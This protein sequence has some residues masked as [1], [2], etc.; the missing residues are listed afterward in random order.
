[1]AHNLSCE[2]NARSRL[3]H[4]ILNADGDKVLR[5]LTACAD[6]THELDQRSQI[7]RMVA[8][9]R[10]QP[11]EVPKDELLAHTSPRKQPRLQAQSQSDT[12]DYVLRSATRRYLPEKIECRSIQRSHRRIDVTT[13]RS[14]LTSARNMR[15]PTESREPAAR[16]TVETSSAA[17]RL[18]HLGHKNY[19]HAQSASGRSDLG[20]LHQSQHYKDSESKRPL[21]TS[22]TWIDP[23]P[24]SKEGGPDIVIGQS[25]VATAVTMLNFD[26]GDGMLDFEVPENVTPDKRT[27]ALEALPS[28]GTARKRSHPGVLTSA[29]ASR[30]WSNRSIGNAE[31]EHIKFVHSFDWAHTPLGPMAEWDP[32]LRQMCD[33]VMSSP[34]PAALYWGEDLTTVYNEAYIVLAGHKHPALMGQSYRIAWAEIWDDVS[35]I[36]ARAMSTG[37]ATMKEDDRLFVRRGTQLEETFF[38][39]SIVPV[40]GKDGSVAGLYNPAFEKTR[41]KIAERR[42]LTLR[43]IGEQTAT[44]KEVRH[45][46]AQV[47]NTFDCNQFDSP[48]A[49][50]YSVSKRDLCETGVIHPSS[51]R[52]VHLC[53]LEGSI[54]VPRGHDCA[55]EYIP[56]G[57]ETNDFGSLFCKAMDTGKPVLLEI[58]THGLPGEKFRDLDW[59]GFG[60]PCKSA[61][62]CPLH[63]TTGGAILGFLVIGI[64]PRRPYDDDYGLFVELLSRQLGTALASVVLF[65]DEIRR[66]QEAAKLA[67]LDRVKLTTQLAVRTKEAEDIQ[68]KF[69]RMAELSPVGMFIASSGGSTTFAN[70]SWYRISRMPRDQGS[71]DRWMNAVKE[72]DQPLAERMWKTLVVDTKPVSF[73]LRFEAVWTDSRGDKGDMWVL[74]SG[75]PELDDEG[76]L[77]C[78]FGSITDISEQKWAES[79]QIKKMEE[80]MELKRQQ[81]NFID[82]TSHEMRNPLSA[83]LQCSDEITG[84][85]TDLKQADRSVALG[86][87]ITRCLEAALTISLCGQ[88]QKRIVDDILTLSRLDSRLL[89]VTP[90]DAQ[91]LA[92]VQRLLKLHESEL[93]AADVE[94]ESVVDRSFHDMKL[95]WLKFDPSRVLQVLINLTTNA[96]KFTIGEKKR[97]ITITVRATRQRPSETGPPLV[98]YVPRRSN[99]CPTESSEWGPG[100]KVFILFSVRDTG[101]GLSSEEKRLLFM[102]FSQASP[103]THVQYGGSGLGLFISRE[104]TELQGG[105][106]GVES[107]AGRG[108]IFAFYVAARRSSRSIDD[109]TSNTVDCD[110]RDKAELINVAADK[111]RVAEAT[112]PEA[113]LM[114]IHKRVLIVEDNLVNQKVLQRQLESLGIEVHLANHGREA[115]DK[116]SRS[117]FCTE[118]EDLQLDVVLMDQEMPVMDGMTCTR[119]IRELTNEGTIRGH[120][121]I[122]GITANARPEQIATALEAGMDD[123]MSKPF[124]V[125]DLVPKIERL[126]SAHPTPD[127]WV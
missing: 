78:V 119:R 67:A 10:K 118:G 84:L 57:R 17:E 51:P 50:L 111:K 25:S 123:V 33:L 27:L 54:G 12:K 8:P 40:V 71:T 82:M 90:I 24:E 58:G 13:T 31:T 61:A 127:N 14:T 59:R 86:N 126:M 29:D 80:A 121:P 93:Q 125:L 92:V 112:L 34:H 113:H 70:D 89:L 64:N 20:H 106:I 100:E 9:K 53:R 11:S 26:T 87:S 77:K 1:M 79:V 76:K 37:E 46:W 101:R 32:S 117:K 107:E 39:W 4:S 15:L 55:P 62:I 75:Q 56:L 94:M 3:D 95:D 88:H 47:I 66:G 91:P 6:Q 72:E 116:L 22:S 99:K 43:E 21:C 68:A 28:A 122:I 38:S 18:N 69:T 63:P 103:R 97:T 41:R 45:F 105:E 114:P 108:S 49:I 98:N 44:I 74:F 109:L 30:N 7:E 60:D 110:G 96:I 42:M 48:F 65:E 35:E 16:T 19:E 115:L 124:R 5:E 23:P 120:V 83:I 36:F 102:R 2:H 52:S 85:L 73:E 104:L 81:E